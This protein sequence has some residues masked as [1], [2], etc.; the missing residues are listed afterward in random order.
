MR[1][2]RSTG[3]MSALNGCMKEQSTRSPLTEIRAA[4]L[5]LRF[6]L[7]TERGHLARNANRDL[8]LALWPEELI[9]YRFLSGSDQLPRLACS[10]CRDAARVASRTLV[11]SPV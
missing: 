6:K 1:N 2:L 4:K 5:I 10:S 9:G 11:S 7:L 3:F 8:H